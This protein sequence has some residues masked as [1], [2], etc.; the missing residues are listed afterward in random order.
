MALVQFQSCVG[1]ECS[2]M[3]GYFL[4]IRMTHLYVKMLVQNDLTDS[5]RCA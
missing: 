2:W 1:Y 3:K 5:L 4:H